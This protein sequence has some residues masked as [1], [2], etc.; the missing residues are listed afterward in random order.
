MN[1]QDAGKQKRKKQKEPKITIE[2][3][4]ISIEGVTVQLE[5]LE[6]LNYMTLIGAEIENKPIE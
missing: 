3:A 5:K 2:V 1:F 4:E 6:N